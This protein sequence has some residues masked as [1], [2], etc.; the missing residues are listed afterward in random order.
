VTTAILFAIILFL[1][2]GTFLGAARPIGKE[3]ATMIG[4]PVRIEAW[5]QPLPGTE[6]E[7]VITIRVGI[8]LKVSGHPLKI[9]QP[10]GMKRT[11]DAIEIGYARYVQWDKKRIAQPPATTA[12][13]VV[14]FL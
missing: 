8:N 7:S 4:K 6:I 11:A 12:P 13:A 2:V 14:F 1:I 10:K 9:A 3:I 5:G